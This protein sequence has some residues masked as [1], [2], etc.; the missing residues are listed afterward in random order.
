[1][2]VYTSLLPH[3]TEAVEK[4]KRLRVGA[5][6]MEMGTGKTLTALELIRLRL[7]AGKIRQVL[8]LCP[9]SVKANLLADIRKHSDL[10]FPILTICG[11]ETLSGSEK[12]AEELLE[13]VMGGAT[14]LIVDES[15]LIKNHKAIRSQRISR[16][17]ESCPYRL[18]LNGTPISRN[19]ADLFNQFY[20]LDWRILGYRSYYSFAANHLEFDDKYPDRIRR[21]LNVDYLT[22]KIAPY[23]YECRKEDCLSLPDKFTTALF[24]GLTV[25]QQE[26]YAAVRE[27]FLSEELFSL[28][29]SQTPVWLYKTFTAL[30]EVAS[31]RRI[32]TGPLKEIRHEPFF[33]D[34]LDNPRIHALD[35]L[36][37]MRIDGDQAVIWHKYRHECEDIETLLAER[38]LKG[39]RLTGE[40]SLKVRER[41]LEMFAKGDTQFLIAN[42]NCGGYGLNL[43]HCHQAVYY[44]NDWDWGTRAQSEDRLHRFGQTHTVTLTD[45][46]AENTIDE[47]IL[48]CLLRKE[49]LSN[50]FKSN[51]K[52]KNLFM[53]RKQ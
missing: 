27:A 39:V 41:N 16:I 6:F 44:S 46:V 11:I 18:I 12:K 17:A 34:P 37:L 2:E 40:E 31:G 53:V 9:F 51:L 7:E 20:I 14:M 36:L 48:K 3:Q 8:W 24:F 25:P 1:M 23:T 22:D 38:N 13:Y 30:Q 52:G 15:A 21:V 19:E 45:I 50:D 49:S 5:L 47:R 32:L 4:L 28:Y 43:Q 26:H 35:D 33:K 29:E 10:G 42:K